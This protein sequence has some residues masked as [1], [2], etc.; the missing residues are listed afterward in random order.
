[1]AAGLAVVAFLVGGGVYVALSR[2]VDP[3]PVA[4]VFDPAATTTLAGELLV[5]PTP[6]RTLA[7]YEG[8]GAW[9][10]VFD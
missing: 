1:M 3:A 5:D 2:V 4:P 8:L 6:A 10:D 9:V 7:P